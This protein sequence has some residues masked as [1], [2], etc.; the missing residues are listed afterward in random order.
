MF[1]DITRSI[2]RKIFKKPLTGIDRT[3]QFY[4][5]Y[6]KDKNYNFLIWNFY[7]FRIITNFEK[8]LLFNK[9]I[10]FFERVQFLFYQIFF[11][12]YGLAK[13]NEKK[14]NN[15]ILINT[16]HYWLDKEIAWSKLKKNNVK[17]VVF[18]HDLLP[19]THPEFSTNYQHYKHCKRISK[20]LKY[21]W[22][23]IVNSNYTLSEI[24]K[25]SEKPNIVNNKIHKINLGADN[26]SK[27]S[28]NKKF[29]FFVSVGKIEIRKN[30]KLLISIWKELIKE[31]F[32]YL[33]K[34]VI[35][36]NKG[37]GYRNII[38]EISTNKKLK[39]YIKVLQGL[40]DYQ[41]QG[42]LK[43]A[44]ATLHPSFYE[45]YGLPLA[46]SLFLK[47]P[48]IAS[49]LI[50]YKEISPNVPEYI[51]A[52]NKK[53]WMRI[54]KNY[55]QPNSLMLNNQVN[56]IK[57]HKNYYWSDHFKKLNQILFQQN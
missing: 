1:L 14:L 40:N 51:S 10:S 25:F 57:S 31:N 37:I 5:N 11:I 49:K 9:N 19:I 12:F 55:S 28:K 24:K 6:F 30:H 38:N 17:V 13:K 43:K 56:K 15:T 54:I 50:V 41:I 20:S 42:Y 21:A 48:A 8:K 33:R 26:Y 36:G 4:I 7:F 32:I 44:R 16:S 52:N 47:I 29:S 2:Y 18:I 39:D 46:E 35:I 34:L 23:I 53:E 22:K 3:T 27:T 45:G